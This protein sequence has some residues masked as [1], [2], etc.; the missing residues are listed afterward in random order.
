[1]RWD[2]IPFDEKATDQQKMDE[3]DAQMR[4][5]NGPP[6]EE[7]EEAARPNRDACKECK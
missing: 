5:N 2:N 1:M 6:P 4:E 7:L 3:F